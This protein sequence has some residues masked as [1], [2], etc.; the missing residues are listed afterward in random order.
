MS[1]NWR[2]SAI[3]AGGAFLL[4]MLVGVIGGVGFGAMLLRALLFG[5]LFGAA[6][7][8][9]TIAIGRFLPELMGAIGS[10]TST[11][12]SGSVD[13]VVDDDAT[14]DIYRA[15]E[16]DSGDQ[17]GDE[18]P[19]DPDS[20]DESGAADSSAS[21]ELDSGS[22]AEDQDIIVDE[23]AV[24]VE[25]V[26]DAEDVEEA[27]GSDTTGLPDLDSFSG[28]FTDGPTEPEELETSS[29]DSRE[30]PAVLARAIQTVLKRQE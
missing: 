11:G 4:S 13:I 24:D 10:E 12:G 25:E 15:A 23:E 9:L 3:T 22:L 18:P 26:E 19:G 20:G 29:L 27:D 14:A 16:N 17:Q 28:S 6:S 30:D 21:G 8:G 1:I 5:L 2:V 7:I